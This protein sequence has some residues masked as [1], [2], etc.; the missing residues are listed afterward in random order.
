MNLQGRKF[1]IHNLGCKVNSYESDAM[2]EALREK[3]ME[4]VDWSENADVYLVNTCSVTN[5]ADKKSRQMLHQAKKKNEN[6]LVVAV[7]CYVQARAEELKKDTAV[8]VL[9]GNGE[10]S[11]LTEILSA[12]E[13]REERE[14]QL[15][16]IR[17]E[18]QFEALHTTERE[19]HQR[20]FVKVQDGCN[21]FCSYCIIPSVRGPIRSREEEETLREIHTL[22]EKGFHEIVLTGIHLSSYG[23]DRQNRSYESVVKDGFPYEDL[24]RLIRRVAAV[25]GIRRIRLGSLEPRIIQEA[26]LKALAEIPAFCPHFHLS[27]QSGADRTLREMNRHYRTAD[28]REGVRL[29]RGYFPDAAVTTDVIVGF[30]G[31]TE[32]DFLESYRFIEEMNFYECHVF[33]YSMRAGTRAAAR[34]DQIPEREKKMREKKLLDLTAIQSERFRERFLYREEEVLFEEEVELEKRKYLRGYNKSYVR[35]LVPAEEMTAY[36]RQIGEIHRVK[37]KKNCKTYVLAEE[38]EIK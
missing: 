15:S 29:I 27:L 36:S 8:D 11:R 30:P 24:L 6:A 7:G 1:A 22:A 3:G 13:R 33:P 21:Q 26:F 23:I 5:I 2:A 35:F 34:K 12:Y 14:R 25:G 4:Q 10:K 19:G 28:F 20:A 32:E 16:P 17:E 31:E 37:A 38:C 9:V 18:K